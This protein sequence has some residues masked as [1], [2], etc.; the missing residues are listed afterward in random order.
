MSAPHGDSGTIAFLRRALL[1]VLL[2]GLVGT[3]TELVLLKH[4]EDQLQL[5]PLA[6]MGLALLVVG[7]H[8]VRPGRASVRVFQGAMAAFAASGATGVF[9]HY[10][11]N[12]EWELERS[13]GVAGLELFR[14]AITGATPTLAPGTMLQLGLIGLLYAYRHPALAVAAEPSP[15]SEK[16]Q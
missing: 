16:R 6:L 13:P 12:V 5:I 2:L 15:S 4:Y 1:A 11:G 14:L 10:R 3:S 8:I 7:W 9:L